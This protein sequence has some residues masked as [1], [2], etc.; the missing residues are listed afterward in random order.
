MRSIPHKALLDYVSTLQATVFGRS[1][2]KL[3]N[4]ECSPTPEDDRSA[5]ARAAEAEWLW[6][7]NLAFAIR[8]GLVLSIRLSFN[9]VP[10]LHDASAGQ[11]AVEVDPLL[12]AIEIPGGVDSPTIRWRTGAGPRTN[13]TA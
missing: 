10:H 3:L 2:L 12:V 5:A 1:W 4:R 7:E 11:W 6:S 13:V 8:L 9:L